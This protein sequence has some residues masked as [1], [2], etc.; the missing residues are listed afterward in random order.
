MLLPLAVAT[1]MAGVWLV[2]RTPAAS[3]YKVV[4][5]LIFLIG[6]ELIYTG[7]ARCWAGDPLA[8]CGERKSGN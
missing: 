4:Y 1:N 7:A 2:R 8:V 6:I 5:V 3:F